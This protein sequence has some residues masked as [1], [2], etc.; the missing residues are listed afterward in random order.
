MIQDGLNTAIH[1][2]SRG[3]SPEAYISEMVF[4]L[5]QLHNTETFLD[6]FD[7]LNTDLICHIEAI[8]DFLLTRG[9]VTASFTGSDTAFETTRTKLG[10][11]LNTMRDEPIPSESVAFQPFE[12]P[13]REGLAGPIQ[14]AYCAHVIPAPHYSHPDSTLLSIGA[15]ILRLDYIMSEIRFKGNAYG[16]Y[17]TYSPFDAQLYQASYRD[18]HV[19]RTLNVFEQAADYVKQVEWTQTD[20]DRAIIATA[21]TAEKPIRP[22]QAASDA[23]SQYLVGQTREMR[24]DRYAQL[25]RATPTEVKRALLQLLEE[26]RDKAAVCVVSSREKLEAANRELAQPL[27]IEDIV[28]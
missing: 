7:E 22:S 28:A 8:R 12:T 24:E 10:E 11:W 21:K 9:R 15:H 14:I 6:N 5:P 17:F 23:L 1:H 18:P 20:I 16:A 4:G 25:R 2:A 19:A 26:N 13:P 27:V 3:L